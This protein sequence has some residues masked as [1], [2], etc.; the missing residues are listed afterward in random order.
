MGHDGVAAT[1]IVEIAERQNSVLGA[2][3]RTIEVGRDVG[4][5]L[6]PVDVIAADIGVGMAEVVQAPVGAGHE[7]GDLEALAGTGAGHS[8]G[9]AADRGRRATRG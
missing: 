9:Q 1:G 6:E 4:H 5:G 3:G 7:R 2:D 8:V